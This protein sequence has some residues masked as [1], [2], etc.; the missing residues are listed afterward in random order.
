MMRNLKVAATNIDSYRGTMFYGLSIL[1]KSN[2]ADIVFSSE[3]PPRRAK[4]YLSKV[5]PLYSSPYL[6]GG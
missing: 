5:T 6:R 3:N 4:I 1:L 2:S